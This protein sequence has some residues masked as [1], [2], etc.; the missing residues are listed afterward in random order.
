[1]PLNYGDEGIKKTF[2]SRKETS[3][4]HT[5]GP[6]SIASKDRSISRCK[7]METRMYIWKFG[8]CNLLYIIVVKNLSYNIP[9][10][11]ISIEIIFT[12]TY[13]VTIKFNFPRYRAKWS[14]RR[15]IIEIFS[16]IVNKQLNAVCLYRSVNSMIIVTNSVGAVRRTYW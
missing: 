11:V 16:I 9:M 12:Y 1:M 4:D 8:V 2:S 13:R 6:F 3:F 10:T 14:L 7:P 5:P 15:N